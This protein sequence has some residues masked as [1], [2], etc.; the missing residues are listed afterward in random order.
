[1][2]IVFSLSLAMR[3][4]TSQRCPKQERDEPD[5][6]HNRRRRHY[7]RITRQRQ[8]VEHRFW[9]SGY[10]GAT[11][12][13]RHDH[14]VKRCH[15]R[16]NCTCKNARGEEWQHDVAERLHGLRTEGPCCTLQRLV[17]PADCRQHG[18]DDE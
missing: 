15:E 10:T 1:M 12:E 6:G 17:A 9:Y 7:R 18:D 13:D 14:I 11:D 5:T 2:A 4:S 8:A 16:K 3:V